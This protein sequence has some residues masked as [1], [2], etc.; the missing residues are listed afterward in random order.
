MV[1]KE[2]SLRL[3]KIRDG[4]KGKV[5]SSAHSTNHLS[6]WCFLYVESLDEFQ[7]RALNDELNGLVR[8]KKAWDFRI[9]Q[10]GGFRARV[11]ER[12]EDV[13]TEGAL[14][15]SY[16]YFGRAREVLPE[17]REWAARLQART[18]GQEYE[19]TGRKERRRLE[20][21]REE[22]QSRLTASYFGIVDAGEEGALLAI[23]QEQS[24]LTDPGK[25][26]VLEGA[27]EFVPRQAD[28]ERALLEHRKQLLLANLPSTDASDDGE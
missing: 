13:G 22:L 24:S 20:R 2:I 3:A 6:D 7:V 19:G 27:F 18:L 21:H 9:R 8:E 1:F 25:G 16:Y 12:F 23:E 14:G 10:L 28:F 17:G 11:N 26:H 5:L 4:K 15:D